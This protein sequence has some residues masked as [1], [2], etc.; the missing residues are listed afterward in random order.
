M[1]PCTLQIFWDLA[2]SSMY[3]QDNSISLKI[4]DDRVLG[5]GG[6]GFVCEGEL[7]TS[8]HVSPNN[9]T[10]FNPEGTHLCFFCVEYAEEEGRCEGVSAGDG[11]RGP[12]LHS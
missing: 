11:R 3:Y 6:Y 4:D 1:T 10:E 5:K 7:V 9:E 2:N 12:T 8:T